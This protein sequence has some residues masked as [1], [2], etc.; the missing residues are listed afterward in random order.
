VRC[1]ALLQGRQSEDGE[2]SV[3]GDPDAWGHFV[4]YLYTGLFDER[5]LDKR[6]QLMNVDEGESQGHIAQAIASDDRELIG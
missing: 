2:I 5:A 3:E 6:Q 1:P 4:H